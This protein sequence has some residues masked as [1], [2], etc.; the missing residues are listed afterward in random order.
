MSFDALATTW[1]ARPRSL[2]EWRYS[3]YHLF[4]GVKYETII[5][6]V[7][8]LSIAIAICVSIAVAIFESEPDLKPGYRDLL[9]AVQ[10][11]VIIMFS[12]EYILRIWTITI[13]ERYK[14][15]FIGRLRYALSFMALIDL[16]VILPFYLPIFSGDNLTF[17]RA[18]RLF[19][20]FR[21]IK[22]GK[23]SES[24]HLIGKVLKLK[25]HELIA[26]LFAVVLLLICA[27]ILMYLIEHP[28]QPNA[29]KSIPD[30]IWWAIATITTV[31]SYSPI[32]PI[33]EAG[34]ILAALISLLG[35]TAIGLPAGIFASGL[36]DIYHRELKHRVHRCPHC[37][38]AFSPSDLQFVEE[39][40]VT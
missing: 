38:K 33:T 37:A 20:L 3:V 6:R 22:L 21:I 8:R 12:V 36:L 35:F 25:R 40:P 26:S 23:Y 27:S 2:Q 39:E 15:P 30:S 4:H 31:S 10:M 28:V 32:M 11:A 14:Q 13:E 29:F 24:L 19:V 18:L 7:V 17:L 34:R 9:D 5:Q 1:R 16:V